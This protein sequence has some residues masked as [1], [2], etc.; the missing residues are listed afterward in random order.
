MLQTIVGD[1]TLKFALQYIKGVHE[2]QVEDLDFLTKDNPIVPSGRE[3]IIKS[4]IYMFLKGQ[5]YE[6]MHILAPQTENLFRNIAKE[7]GGL[8][9]TLENDGTSKEK[10]LSSIFDLPELNDCY[11]NDILFMFRE[12]LNEKAGANIRNEV[13]HGLLSESG[14]ASGACLYFACAVIKLLSYTSP[15]CYRTLKTSAKL[16]TFIEPEE[17]ALKI[18]QVRNSMMK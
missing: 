2:F 4:A 3:R 10:V 16:K 14:A 17:T 13:A 12:L 7:V 5:Y 6:S 8:T 11:D 18:K 9:V 1:F 15:R